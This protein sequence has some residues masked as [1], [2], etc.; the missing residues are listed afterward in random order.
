MTLRFILTSLLLWQLSVTAQAAPL[1]QV[2]M[3]LVAYTDLKLINNETW[4]E[5]LDTT[6]IKK[7][8]SITRWWL[9]PSIKNYHALI[10]DY[11]F[12][13]NPQAAWQYSMQALESADLQRA[14]QRIQNNT[15]MQ[16]LWHKAWIEPI[17][18]KDNAIVHPVNIHL[19]PE[20]NRLNQ[21]LNLSGSFSLYLSRYLHIRSNLV[22]QHSRVGHPSELVDPDSED[23]ESETSQSLDALISELSKEAENELAEYADDNIELAEEPETVLIPVRAGHIQLQRRMRSTELHYID[24]P[25]LGVI[26]RVTPTS[27]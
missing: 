24:H 18:E 21:D 5:S 20:A 13:K 27:N 1:Y 23:V 8:N 11:G 14:V 26:V 12:S 3:I 17:G 2:E 19:A 16:L 15:G 9:T 6:N 7:S 10:A 22:M 25:M 4:P